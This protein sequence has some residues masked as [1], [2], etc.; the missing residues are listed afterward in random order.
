[1]ASSDDEIYQGAA[2][3]DESALRELVSSS[4][5]HVERVCAF[6]LGEDES[7]GGAVVGTYGRALNHL[8]KGPK[9]GLPLKGWLGILATQECF[10]TLQRLRTEYDQQTQM[11]EDLASKIPTLVEIS[12]D[13]KERVNF[14]IR[15]D[16]EDIPDQH[17]QVLTLSE[18]EGL[19]FLDLAKRLSCSWAMALNR[20]LLARQALAKR[21]KE[22]FGL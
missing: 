19:H 11:L 10:H 5:E 8:S 20:L 14:M 7:L 4:R 6:F 17:K 21:V 16:I 15:G 1:M 9:P 3:G 18:L 13:P 22:S 2:D 12:A